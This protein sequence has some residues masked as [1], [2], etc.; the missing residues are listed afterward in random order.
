MLADQQ[1]AATVDLDGAAF[2]SEGRGDRGCALVRRDPAVE[3]VLFLVDEATAALC[4][5]GF[6]GIEMTRTPNRQAIAVPLEVD[7]VRFAVLILGEYQR[8]ADEIGCCRMRGK[9][10]PFDRDAL[11]VECG[12]DGDGLCF[13]CSQNA[14]GRMGREC[15]NHGSRHS[16]LIGVI[17]CSADPHRLYRLEL[18]RNAARPRRDQSGSTGA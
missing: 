10:D 9:A 12:L 11:P 7:N 15:S 4:A 18:G 13:A 8:V 3:S 16:H 1:Y 6:I 5:A 2:K 14:D 17:G